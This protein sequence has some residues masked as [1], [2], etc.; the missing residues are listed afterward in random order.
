MRDYQQIL[1][2]YVDDIK[3]GRIPAC[4]YVKKAVQRFT[5]DLKRSKDADFLFV[6][7]P[8]KADMICD[9]AETLK[10]ADLNGR[11][12]PLL[13]WQ[14]FVLC[15]L[16]GWR[17]KSD[18]N[19][20]R[21]RT[22]Y[23]EV[24][25]KNAK[26]T[27]ILE[28]MTLWNFLKYPAAESYL[29]SSRDD[30]AEKTFK[31]IAYMIHADKSLDELLNPMSLAVTFKDPKE[32]SRLGFFCDGAKDT[33]GFKPVFCAIDEFHAYASDKILMSMQYG[34]RSKKDAQLVVITTADVS[35]DNP[36][37]ELTNKSRRILNKIQEQDDFFCIIYTVDEDD[38]WRDPKNWIKS[39]PSLNVIIDPSVIQSDIDD[40][41]AT[42]HKQAELKAKT[43]NI[44]GGGSINTW[45]SLDKWQQNKDKVIDDKILLEAPCLMGLDI[46]QVGDLCGYKKLWLLDDGFE[47]YE[48]SFYIPE[49]SL[50]E[51]YKSENFNYMSWAENGIIKTIPGD[52]IDYEIIANDILA[53]CAKYKVKALG[54][55]P[56]QAKIIINI[57]E[58]NRP[59]LLLVCIEQSLKKLAPIFKSYE[60]A[61]LDGKIID[62]SPLSLWSVQNVVV[63]PDENDNYKPMKRSKASVHRID[64]VVAATMAHG[65]AMLPEVQQIL[66][67]KA[68]SFETLKALL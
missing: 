26:T 45:M 66:N 61:I 42:P 49:N 57:L 44:W 7:A 21:F 3:K 25:R 2:Q 39:N 53:D 50:R 51:R 15:N 64:P 62:N 9:F 68:M 35:T 1:N 20:K 31:E 10:P 22:G 40:A 58:E 34:M 29:V 36:C 54:Y 32:A 23:V 16:E 18:I 60:K 38:D 56:W 27:N 65:V 47:Y 17:H 8:E 5:S 13:P 14:V 52:T 6:Y 55:D 24:A 33:D 19:R 67:A 30:L 48:N 12:I 59:D 63:R 11:A 4:A 43:F 28:P 41:D 37:F 46:A